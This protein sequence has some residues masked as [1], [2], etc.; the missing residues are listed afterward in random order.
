MDDDNDDDDPTR[1]QSSP[2]PTEARS[3]SLAT[4]DAYDREPAS[5]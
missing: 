3:S 1:H 4:Y 2:T 5:T